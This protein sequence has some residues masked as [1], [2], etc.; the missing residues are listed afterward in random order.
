MIHN[1]QIMEILPHRYPMLLIDAVTVLEYDSYCEAIKNITCNEPCYKELSDSPGLCDFAYPCSLIIE[2]FSQAAAI[3]YTMSQRQKGHSVKGVMLF[4]SISHF[5][6]HRC[7]FPGNTMRHCVTLDRD[8]T[9]AA[10]I[11]G[12]VWVQDE[13]IARVDRELIA[14]RPEQ[15]VFSRFKGI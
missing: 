6:F 3:L 8:L 15:E 1:A 4:G 5:I 7:A 13:R 2:S 9:D 11:S 12:E 10:V 14:V